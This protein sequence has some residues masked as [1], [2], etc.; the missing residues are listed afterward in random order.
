MRPTQLT[1]QA[2]QASHA[3]PHPD[4]RRP[5][6]LAKRGSGAQAGWWRWVAVAHNEAITP[7]E[8][9]AAF[10][11]LFYQSPTG[12]LILDTELR[13]LR[14]NVTRPVL[15]E[16]PP[17][18][19]IG[20]HFTDVYDFSAPGDVEAMLRGVL[21]SGAPARGRLVGVRP[22]GAPGP[23][24][25]FS[26]SASRLQS[27]QGRVLGVL[28]EMLDVTEREKVSARLHVVGSVRE[29]VGQT[30]DVVA[31]CEGTGAGGGAGL[32][33]HRRGGCGG[34]SDTGREPSAE[35]SGTGGAAAPCRLRPQRRRRADPG[36]SGG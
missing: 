19:I 3:D 16:A 26:V 29:H 11:T 2:E 27:P 7:V 25:L 35:P 15:H 8:D 33:R 34:R 9:A 12:L 20:R 6:R 17:E 24:Y 10:E 21:E 5:T 1:A 36:T 32:R 18:Q 14:I 31:T 30:L 4:P 23:K 22:K 28:V 13:I